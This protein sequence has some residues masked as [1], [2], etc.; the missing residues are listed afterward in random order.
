[1]VTIFLGSIEFETL[2]GESEVD[3]AAVLLSSWVRS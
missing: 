2:F 1:M 3:R